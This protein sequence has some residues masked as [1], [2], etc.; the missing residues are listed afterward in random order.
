M[1]HF[2]LTS[3]HVFDIIVALAC[4]VFVVIGIKRGLIGEVVRFAAVAAGIAAALMF[5]RQ[6]Y[7]QLPLPFSDS[8]RLVIA[9]VALFLAAVI[10]VIAIGW[11][12][13]KVI[14]LT[15]LGWVDRAG[16]A[17]LGALKVAAIAWVFVRSVET[18]PFP[19][20]KNNLRRS[21]AYSTL[22][23]L[24][25]KLA[26]PYLLKAAGPSRHNVDKVPF[27]DKIEAAKK[28]L[29]KVRTKVDSA[30]AVYERLHGTE[31]GKHQ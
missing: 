29:D 14:R 5:Y 3:V 25:P 27:T 19:G 7:Q 6:L 21:F 20:Y 12:V 23:A 9:F 28:E 2:L 24:P 31:R 1:P 18:S 22:A 11:A 26:V 13:Q 4:A 16:G 10:A 17:A 8:A 30:E 15:V